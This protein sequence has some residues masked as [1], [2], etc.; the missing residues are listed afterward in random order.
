MEFW[1]WYWSG[2]KAVFG[3]KWIKH[4]ATE[5]AL[6]FII[7]GIVAGI[8]AAVFTPLWLILVLPVGCTAIVH[9]LWRWNKQVSR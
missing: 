4:P 8:V 7:T 2:L 5:Y 6:A 3:G 9:G 1:K